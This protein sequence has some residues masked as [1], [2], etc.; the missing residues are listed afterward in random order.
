M[1]GQ[2]A[3]GMR[4]KARGRRHEVKKQVEGIKFKELII[5]CRR[6]VYQVWLANLTLF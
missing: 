6:Q 3:G 2:E 5:Y 4:Y 1:K